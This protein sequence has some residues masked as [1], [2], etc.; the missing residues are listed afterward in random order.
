[1]YSLIIVGTVAC[2]L[3]VSVTS[4][5]QQ[6]S[7]GIDVSPRFSIPFAERIKSRANSKGFGFAETVRYYCALGM[8]AEDFLLKRNP[9][10]G[11]IDETRPARCRSNR[12]V[13]GIDSDLIPHLENNPWGFASKSKYVNHC[14]RKDIV[15]RKNNHERK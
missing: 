2:L 11:N 6:S 5:S 3:L 8:E 12:Q 14:I 4:K 13:L 10:M 7:K 1:M 9:E 15:A